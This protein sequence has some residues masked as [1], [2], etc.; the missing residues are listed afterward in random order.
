[1]KPYFL[2]L[3]LLFALQLHAEPGYQK[4]QD[5]KLETYSFNGYLESYHSDFRE[6]LVVNGSLFASKSRFSELEVNGEARLHECIL[7][8]YGIIR[9]ELIVDHSVLEGPIEAAARQ[10]AIVRCVTDNIKIN[11]AGDYEGPQILKISRGSVINGNI[12][13]ESR[14]GQVHLSRDSRILGGVIGG[15]ICPFIE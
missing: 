3:T 12:V 15:T 4:L 1:M 11:H 7:Y 9:G 8:D 6:S 2:A 10:V 5:Q 14:N 13:F